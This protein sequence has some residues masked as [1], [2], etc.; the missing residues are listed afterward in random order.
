MA[1]LHVRHVQQVP[2]DTNRAT[3]EFE[4]PVSRSRLPLVDGLTGCQV[5]LSQNV[6]LQ[7]L[8]AGYIHTVTVLFSGHDPDQNNDILDSG[9]TLL[10]CYL[11]KRGKD[12][13]RIA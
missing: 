8:D 11:H 1:A 9:R 4:D 10:S 13:G 2:S 12:P 5:R 3:D 6:S 7:N